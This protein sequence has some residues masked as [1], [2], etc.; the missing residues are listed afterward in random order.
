MASK[1]ELTRAKIIDQAT[2]VFHRKGFL[3]TTI[4]D[5]LA[6]T[7]TTKGNLYFHFSSK[8]DVAAEV[9]RQAHEGFR[10]FLESSLDGPTP[11]A[12]LDNFFRQALE[13]NRSKGFVG[14]CL[15]GNTAL[16]A[17]D[18]APQLAALVAEVFSEWIGT[19][20]EIIAA[21]Q[22]TGE[23]RCDLPAADLAGF[24]VSALEGAIMLSRLNKREEP[25]AGVL[26]T[27]RSMLDLR[28]AESP[29][30]TRHLPSTRKKRDG[31]KG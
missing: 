24:V 20:Q 23:V 22:A 30:K 29:V 13:R 25:L 9:L 10:H 17:S 5:L 7:G 12:K 27:L 11:G 4:N 28:I 3:S 8:E 31:G 2:Q 26:N 6:A 14:G 16:E 21:A 15:F 19:L 18:N 1:G